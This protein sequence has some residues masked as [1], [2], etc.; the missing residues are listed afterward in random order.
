[1][2]MNLAS[3]PSADISSSNNNVKEKRN[4]LT[5]H[6]KLSEKVVRTCTTDFMLDE[7][8]I[9]CDVGK[10]SQ[11]IKIVALSALQASI[12]NIDECITLQNASK[13]QIIH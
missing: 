10:A 3:T 12:T 13:N 2:H 5:D 1:M 6:T 11:D 4:I 7:C 8:S 9:I